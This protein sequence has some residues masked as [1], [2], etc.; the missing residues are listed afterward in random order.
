MMY[1]GLTYYEQDG[2]EDLMIFVAAKDLNALL[3]VFSLQCCHFIMCIQ[4]VQDHHKEAKSGQNISFYIEDSKYVK[5]ILDHTPQKYP[6][7]GWI[8][9]S[10]V[11]PCLVS[12]NYIIIITIFKLLLVV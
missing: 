11:E 7:T 12:H 10:H 1:A 4:F 5:L 8:I 6:S 3:E 2:V 9:Q